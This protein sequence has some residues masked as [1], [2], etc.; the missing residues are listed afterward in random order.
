MSQLNTIGWKSPLAIQFLKGK[1]EM[2]Q[3][4]DENQKKGASGDK[5]QSNL[6]GLDALMRELKGQTYPPVHLWNPEFC[7]EMDMR[8]ARNGQWYYMGTPIG[9][10]EMVRLFSTVLRYDA[11]EIGPEDK[12]TIDYKSGQYFLVTPVEK[13]G[14][15]VDD[16]P[17]LAITMEVKGEG[18]AQVVSFRTQTGDLIVASDNNPIMV[19]FDE[20]TL[21]PSPYVLVRDNLRALI[22]RPLFYDMV[23]MA[24]EVKKMGSSDEKTKLAV[25]SSGTLFVIGDI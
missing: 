13:L 21:E 16:A 8:I 6:K 20:K 7:G 10:P 17:F 1:G 15:Q 2:S 12:K 22:N 19:E 9:R 24:V 25:W 14:I 3:K 18:K 4:Q 23:N 5:P 11:P